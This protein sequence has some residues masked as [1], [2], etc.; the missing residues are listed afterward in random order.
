M[1]MG[2]HRILG[3]I[4]VN[5]LSP[6]V[7]VMMVPG[8]WTPALSMQI[9]HVAMS[10][11]KHVVWRLPLSLKRDGGNWADKIYIL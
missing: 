4:T 5:T 1:S 6:S 2:C 11:V 9:R 10:G 8:Q 7:N 3:G